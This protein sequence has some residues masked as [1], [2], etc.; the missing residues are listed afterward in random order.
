MG[1]MGSHKLNS[2]EGHQV[3]W[4]L[5]SHVEMYIRIV[6][7]PPM[8]SPNCGITWK[9]CTRERWDPTWLFDHCRELCPL[10]VPSWLMCVMLSG[11]FPCKVYIDSN[12]RDSLGYEWWLAATP[13]RSNWTSF[14]IHMYIEIDIDDEDYNYLYH[15][16]IDNNYMLSIGYKPMM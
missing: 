10:V 12:L 2:F 14:M 13:K 1:F 4:Y 8:D 16:L 5:T 15:K 11:Y 9:M 6:Y 7:R 3:G